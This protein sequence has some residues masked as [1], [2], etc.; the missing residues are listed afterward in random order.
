M[1]ASVLIERGLHESGATAEK[2]GD[3]WLDIHVMLSRTTRLTDWLLRRAPPVSFLLQGPQKDSQTRL[4]GLAR[5][6]SLC[7]A[8]AQQLVRKLGFQSLLH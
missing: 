3:W 8:T 4:Q 1:R 5:R 7:H 6:A 2:D